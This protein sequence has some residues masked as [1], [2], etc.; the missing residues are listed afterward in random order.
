MAHRC[1]TP[2]SGGDLCELQPLACVIVM[3][4]LIIP[5][6]S[7]DGAAKG[8]RFIG[9]ARRRNNR[10]LVESRRNLLPGRGMN[11]N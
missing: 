6:V 11:Y 9:G 1:A 10:C 3:P 8:R 4:L 7:F 2:P 5:D